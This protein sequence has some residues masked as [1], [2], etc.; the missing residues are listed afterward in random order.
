MERYKDDGPFIFYKGAEPIPYRSGITERSQLSR[1]M[2]PACGQGDASGRDCN[3]WLDTHFEKPAKDHVRALL[4]GKA[5]SGSAVEAA[6]SWAVKTLLLEQHPE[7]HDAEL[8][9]HERESWPNLDTLLFPMRATGQ[10]PPDLSLWCTVTSQE[11]AGPDTPD[12]VVL[13]PHLH[14]AGQAPAVFEFSAFGYGMTG[15]RQLALQ[16]LHHPYVEVEHPFEAANL[17]TRLWPEPPTTLDPAEMPTLGIQGTQHWNRTFCK[18]GDMTDL[19]LIRM[20]QSA[21]FHELVSPR[22]T[23]REPRSGG[24]AV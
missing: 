15:G 11:E 1:V 23:V 14:V 24:L 16:L 8:P 20:S 22:I 17:A 9:N 7:A 5:I 4:N 2:A 10:L 6:A 18:G 13:L 12:E 19:N 3:G 21:F